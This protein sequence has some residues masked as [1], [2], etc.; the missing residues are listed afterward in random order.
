MVRI[1]S[2]HASKRVKEG[3]GSSHTSIH[4]SNQLFLFCYGIILYSNTI[5]NNAVAKQKQL[6]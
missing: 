2:C 3:D 5:Q 1:H 6:I 4:V